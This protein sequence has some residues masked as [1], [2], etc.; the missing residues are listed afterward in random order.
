MRGDRPNREPLEPAG[1]SY[2]PRLAPELRRLL[3]RKT[4]SAATP[5]ERSER[6]IFGKV[7]QDQDRHASALCVFPSDEAPGLTNARGQR[8]PQEVD[9]VGRELE[10]TASRIVARR[11]LQPRGAP[12][13]NRARR[14]FGPG[15]A[16]GRLR[17]GN[18]DGLGQRR[19]P[20]LALTRRPVLPLIRCPRSIPSKGSRS[21]PSNRGMNGVCFV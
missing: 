7:R 6:A 12:G 14:I 5:A 9:E 21:R 4:R 3:T 8:V 2:V 10:G 11:D 17:L 16:N 15:N 19:F 20:P 13:G 1:L 18:R